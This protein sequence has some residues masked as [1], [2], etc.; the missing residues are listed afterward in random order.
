LTVEE[1]ISTITNVYNNFVYTGWLSFSGKQNR[2]AGANPAQSRYCNW[3]GNSSPPLRRETRATVLIEN[4]K[5][6]RGV[7]EPEVRRPAW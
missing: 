5:A 1:I 3:Q 2:E 6:R 4:G 7:R